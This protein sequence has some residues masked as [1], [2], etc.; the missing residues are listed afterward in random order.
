MQKKMAEAAKEIAQKK[1][2][3]KDKELQSIKSIQKLSPGPA[4]MKPTGPIVDKSE[5]KEPLKEIKP[6]P[7]KCPPMKAEF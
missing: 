2:D 5:K 7:G 3:C 4:I 6:K 1:A